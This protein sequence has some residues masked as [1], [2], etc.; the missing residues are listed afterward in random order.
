MCRGACAAASAR[1]DAARGWAPADADDASMA[2]QDTAAASASHLWPRRLR[3]IPSSR[4]LTSTGY[5]THGAEL[6]TDRCRYREL[7]VNPPARR[8]TGR[9]ADS[10]RSGE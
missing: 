10:F 6:V 8:P 9:P 7:P 4:V 5:L 2:A 1:C 3:M